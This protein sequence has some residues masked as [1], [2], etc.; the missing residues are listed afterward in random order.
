MS[1]NISKVTIHTSPDVV[2]RFLTEPQL[3]KK[4]QY[5][6]KLDT[7]W[8][9]GS[10]IRFSSEWEGVTYEQW[11][12]VQAY[13]P[14]Q[15]VT[16]SLFAPRPGLE[17]IPENYFVMTYALEENDGQT[18][19]TVTQEDNRPQLEEPAIEHAEDE[20]SIL[21]TLKTLAEADS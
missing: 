18:V 3:V 16:Y 12:E 11:G 20:P 8:Q 2:W 13:V 6:S 19:V 14:N 9:I 7:D 5:G 10:E 17:D 1:K 4:W 21:D 15:L